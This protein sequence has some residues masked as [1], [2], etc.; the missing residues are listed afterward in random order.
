ME[1][2]GLPVD[3][4]ARRALDAEFDI[5]QRELLVEITA[6]A[7]SECG[8]VHPKVGYR[9]APPELKSY[10]TAMCRQFDDTNALLVSFSAQGF[11]ELNDG[12]FYH[13]ESRL[14]DV[15]IVDDAGEPSTM[16]MPRWCRVYDFN[17]N[18]PTQLKQYMRVRNHKVPK[19]KD[20]DA[21]GNQKDTT[22]KKE[23]VRLAR[24]TGD[25]F[26]L[27]V[28][29][30]RELTKLRGTYIEGFAPAADGCVHT[31]FTF[32]TG[33]GQLSSRNPNIQNF[34]KHGS[35][36]SGR[37]LNHAIRKMIAAKPG[38]VLVEWDFKSCHVLTLGYLARDTTFIRLARLDMHSFVTGHI[39]GLWDG[40]TILRETDDQL[41]ARFKWLKS[42]AEYK[43]IRDDQ[44][45]HAILG[46]GNGLKAK[47]L[48]ERYMEE[49]ADQRTAK[50]FLDVAEQLFP[51]VFA[52]QRAIQRRAHEQR[53]L[54]TEFRHIRRF[55]E[56]FR[57]D[58]RRGDWGH[59]DQAEEAISFWLSNIAF[60]H[61][62]DKMKD[63]A[64]RGLDAEY[65]LVNNVHDSYLFHFRADRIA[66]HVRDVYP[67][68]I[69][70]SRVLVDPEIAPGGLHIDVEASAGV[71][72][73]EMADVDIRRYMSGNDDDGA[74][75]GAAR[76]VSP[77]DRQE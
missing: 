41:R 60:G 14:F 29:H 68:L 19:S 45:K 75:V 55:Y 43:R 5:A 46:I 21:D 33:I 53:Y 65:G 16:I 35:T 64:A 6:A 63:L 10:I 1:D 66:Q 50:R 48:Y 77:S 56:V 2:R 13:Y 8:R 4:A 49:F 34:P 37:R 69:A 7:P 76:A 28:I 39:L 74:L 24:R 12:E 44:A 54:K 67:V 26:Y 57:W 36:E 61:I 27:K 3:D 62:R 40:P 42:N 15:P 73:S 23:L 71:N 70:P 51:K 9:G 47:G 31:T 32:D 11:R 22:A 20:E 30:Y 38:N 58:A 72:W 25:A 18:S 17:P 59:G 52:W